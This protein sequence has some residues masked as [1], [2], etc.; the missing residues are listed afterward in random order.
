ME[1]NSELTFEEALK[2][3]EEI[4]RALDEKELDLDKAI[5][6]YEEGLVLIHFC[7][8]KLKQARAR[9]EVIL[10]GKEGVTLE[11]LERAKELLKNG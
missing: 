6:L 7:E 8:E 9:V 3:L 10:K 5:T 1:G 4:V 2:R 11:S